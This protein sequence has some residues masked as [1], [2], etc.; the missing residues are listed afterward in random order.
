MHHYTFKT[1][2]DITNLDSRNLDWEETNDLEKFYALIKSVTLSPNIDNDITDQF[3]IA[4]NAFIYAWYSYPLARLASLHA[5]GTLELSLRRY[6][7]D[8]QKKRNHLDNSLRS[9]LDQAQKKEYISIECV[10][11]DKTP[12]DAKKWVCDY[13]NNVGHGALNLQ[14]PLFEII[15]I[16]VCANLLNQMYTRIKQHNLKPTWNGWY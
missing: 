12:D 10:M 1:F 8:A 16:E 9:L 2:D 5:I 13:R 3:N 6:L 14:Q 7:G 4:K 15:P 11:P